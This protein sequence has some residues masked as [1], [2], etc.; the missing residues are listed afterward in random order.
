M[1]AKGIQTSG[2]FCLCYRGYQ[3]MDDDTAYLLSAGGI[4]R[5][6]LMG[7]ATKY[8]KRTKQ[9]I[10]DAESDLLASG[11]GGNPL[12]KFRGRVLVPPQLFD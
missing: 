5:T 10:D 3:E 7:L 12:I 8:G 4:V 9:S 1:I 6:S 2:W 11:L